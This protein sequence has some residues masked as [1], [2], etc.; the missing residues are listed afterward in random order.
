MAMVKSQNQKHKLTQGITM[1]TMV[2]DTVDQSGFFL[3]VFNL[4]G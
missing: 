3:Q 1:S 4:I 2:Q